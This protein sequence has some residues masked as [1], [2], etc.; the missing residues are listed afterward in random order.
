MNPAQARDYG[1]LDEVVAAADLSAAAGRV[2]QDFSRLD[3]P[4]YQATKQAL[5]RQVIEEVQA[6]KRMF[7]G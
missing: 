2:I 5:N 7:N 1:Y 4:S 3:T 6:S